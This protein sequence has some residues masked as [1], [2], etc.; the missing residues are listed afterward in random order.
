M[1]TSCLQSSSPRLISSS[2]WV[3]EE[4]PGCFHLGPYDEIASFKITC[5]EVK[6]DPSPTQNPN[7][8]VRGEP[9]LQ[10]AVNG[11]FSLGKKDGVDW[12]RAMVRALMGWGAVEGVCVLCLD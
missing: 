11:A 12:K 1:D 3:A 9:T 2:S 7:G 6:A 8:T 10:T 4:A 5:R